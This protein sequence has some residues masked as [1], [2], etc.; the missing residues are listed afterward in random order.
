MKY[1]TIEELCHSDTAVARKIDNSPTRV[2]V[3]NLEALVL[4][5]LDP[6]REAYGKPIRVNSGY[7]SPRLNLVIG[8][9]KN[10]QHMVGEAVDITTGSKE[11]NKWLFDY[12]FRHLP[13][14]QLIDESSY[15]WVHVSFKNNDTNRQQVLRL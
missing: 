2:V 10:S 15:S 11:D 3:E 14:D 9:A 4:N 8:G 5:V 13:Y 7:R 6:L 12:I 1:F